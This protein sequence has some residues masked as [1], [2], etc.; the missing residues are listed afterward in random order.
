MIKTFYIKPDVAAGTSA[1]GS[2]QDGGSAPTTADT[3][4]QW[5][6]GTTPAGNYAK[7]FRNTQRQPADFNTTVQ[8]DG[9]L[10]NAHGDCLRTENA[11]T[12]TFV[13]GNWTFSF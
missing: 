2:L 8:P 12:G 1:H 10:D 13:S 3:N 6:C 7:Y 9:S 4:S 11:Y 5:K